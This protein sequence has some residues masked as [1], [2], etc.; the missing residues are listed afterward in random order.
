MESQ[1]A[2]VN[3]WTSKEPL[4]FLGIY[5]FFFLISTYVNL[6]PLSLPPSTSYDVPMHVHSN[7][8]SLPE[9]SLAL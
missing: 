5:S 4:V 8:R 2:R 7:T 1:H 9:S 3:P 6:A